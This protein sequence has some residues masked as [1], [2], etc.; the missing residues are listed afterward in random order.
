MEHINWTEL[1]MA[2]PLLLEESIIIDLI[3]IN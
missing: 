3:R 2:V 1:I